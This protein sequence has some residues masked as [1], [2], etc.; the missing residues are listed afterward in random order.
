[1]RKEDSMR[2][3]AIMTLSVL[4]S[5]PTSVFANTVHYKGLKTK[6]TKTATKPET[7]QKDEAK[8]GSQAPELAFAGKEK[9]DFLIKMGGSLKIFATGEFAERIKKEP[10]VKITLYLNGVP[11][12]N[13]TPSLLQ[14]PD[15]KEVTVTF[16]LVRD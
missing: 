9:K 14:N 16:G 5:F 11:M 3:L 8:R 13:L 6:P 1:M 7:G 4:L 12:T 2:Y 15:G 10:S